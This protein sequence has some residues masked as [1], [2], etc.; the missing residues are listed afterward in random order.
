MNAAACSARKKF[1]HHQAIK[2]TAGSVFK[3][4]CEKMELSALNLPFDTR[5]LLHV[6]DLLRLQF[7]IFI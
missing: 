2:I 4:K 7:V 3:N 6:L 5:H 1:K